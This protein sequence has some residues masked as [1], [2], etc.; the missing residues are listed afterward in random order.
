MSSIEH[1][2]NINDIPV[3]QPIHPPGCVA[4]QFCWSQQHQ[5]GQLSQLFPF[6]FLWIHCAQSQ[7]NKSWNKER[8]IKCY[9]KSLL[10]TQWI[11]N[12]YAR[13]KCFTCYASWAAPSLWHC[14]QQISWNHL[15]DSD[16]SSC[17][18]HNQC[19][20]SK[21]IPWTFS[22]HENQYPWVC[23]SSA[24]EKEIEKTNLY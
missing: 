9:H 21:C 11:Q 19:L 22:W 12:Q 23:A 6:S 1:Y 16:V 7:H 8:E 24:V 3:I 4:W 14:A 18:N 13:T 5:A 17:L 2:K 15:E 20:A 10:T